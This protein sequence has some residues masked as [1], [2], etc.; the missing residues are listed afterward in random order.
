MGDRGG[1][2]D[3]THT[4]TTH[5]GFG[6]FHAAFFADDTAVLEALVLAAEAFVVLDRPEDFGAEQAVAFRLEGAVVDRFRFFDFA[7]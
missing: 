2:F 3:M 6:D 5:A 4:L 7:E 1:Q